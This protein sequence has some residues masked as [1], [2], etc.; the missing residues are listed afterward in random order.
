[1]RLT[2]GR[3][4]GG[5]LDARWGDLADRYGPWSTSLLYLC[6]HSFA[7]FS[8]LIEARDDPWI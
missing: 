2:G 3:K 8:L 4:R 5:Y 7:F 1:M 6:F